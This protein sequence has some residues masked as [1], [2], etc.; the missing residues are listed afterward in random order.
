[1]A[2]EKPSAERSISIIVT[3]MNEEGNLRPTIEGIVDAVSPRFSAF[4]VIIVDD[5]STDATPAIADQLAA[6]DSHIVVHHHSRNL[7]LASSYRAGIELAR[8]HYTSWIAGNNLIPPEGFD[9]IYGSVGV[10]EVVTTYL[11]SDVRGRIRRALSTT[12]TRGMNLLFGTELRYFTGPCVYPTATLK[13]VDAVSQGS[14][15]VAEVLLRVL[16]SDASYSTVGIQPLPRTSGSTK[17]FR[18]KNIA[19]VLSSVARLFWLLRVRGEAPLKGGDGPSRGR[20]QIA[21]L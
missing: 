10:A 11:R 3:A 18:L 6:A 14:M 2:A 12:F 13:R 17:S 15:F 1:M 7:G 16:L 8:L 21:A 4:E 9:D 20:D 5:G 19:A